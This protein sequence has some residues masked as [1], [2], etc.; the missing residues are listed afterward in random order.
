MEVRENYVYHTER[1]LPP[2]SCL[3]FSKNVV[4]DYPYVATARSAA[5]LD[6]LPRALGERH[7]R[8]MTYPLSV[9]RR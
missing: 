7:P 3:N 5:A 2:V 8:T 9:S 6:V 1:E 4:V